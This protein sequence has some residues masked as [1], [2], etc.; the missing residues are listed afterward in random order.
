M[1]GCHSGFFCE[2]PCEMI[3]TDIRLFCKCIQ[4]EGFVKVLIYIGDGIC[5]RRS[6]KDASF[7]ALPGKEKTV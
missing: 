3:R 1:V 6:A 4:R 5:N 2:D 7:F